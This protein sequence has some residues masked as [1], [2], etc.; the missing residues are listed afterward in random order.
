[1]KLLKED[2][3]MWLSI[4]SRLSTRQERSYKMLA[5]SLSLSNAIG[6]TSKL[7]SKLLNKK[8]KWFKESF[9]LCDT[10][11]NLKQIWILT[12]LK[13]P[14]LPES[15]LHSSPQVQASK[16]QSISLSTR[17]KLIA[18]WAATVRLDLIA[19][20]YAMVNPNQLPSSHLSCK[21]AQ[22]WGMSPTT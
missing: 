19:L 6:M 22:S 18:P 21:M 5:K 11:S 17:C 15:E 16:L 9:S 13:V 8:E 1:M 7:L 14:L 12:T 20:P 2:A 10:S 3:L 4:R